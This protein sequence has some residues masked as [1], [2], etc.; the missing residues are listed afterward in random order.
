MY[1]NGFLFEVVKNGIIGKIDGEA[2][3]V[4][5]IVLFQGG[6]MYDRVEVTE[7]TVNEN[8]AYGYWKPL[9]AEDFDI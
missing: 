9:T 7:G 2:S 6:Q 8:I 3:G 5:S 1:K 4:Y